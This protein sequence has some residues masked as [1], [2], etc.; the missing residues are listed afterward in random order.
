MKSQFARGIG[1]ACTA[2]L[3]TVALAAPGTA[4]AKTSTACSGPNV[5]GQ[6][7]STQKIIQINFWNKLFNESSN[8]YACSGSQG[9]GKKPTVIYHSTGSGAG[10]KS[11]GIENSEAETPNYS[12]SNAYLGTD[13][14]P[15]AAQAALLVKHESPETPGSG[16]DDSGHA[17]RSFG[18]R[19]PARGLHGDL[20]SLDRPSGAQP[21]RARGHLLRF[22]QNMGGL[23]AGGDKVIGTGCSTDAIQPVVREDQSGTT[24]IFSGS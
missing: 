24:H 15:S 19:E 18:H 3:A 12:A 10:L 17:G 4:L 16:P 23:T 9:D 1:L 2:A 21:D 20:G 22:D 6:G 11:W 14:P 13:E 5:E 8:K 7:A